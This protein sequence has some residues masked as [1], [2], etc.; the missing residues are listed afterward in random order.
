MEIFEK[1]EPGEMDCIIM[2][3]MMPV[4]DGLQAAKEIRKLSREDAKTIPMIAL[5]ANAF[6]E[7]RKKT[8]E[9]GMNQHVSKPL[10]ANQLFAILTQYKKQK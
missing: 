1:S 9:A 7:D 5:S 10:D 2:D 8:R 6:E 4:M 3:V